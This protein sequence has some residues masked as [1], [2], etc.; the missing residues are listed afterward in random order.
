MY[1][2][3]NCQNNSGHIHFSG[4]QIERLD[5]VAT[6]NEA[7]AGI[8]CAVDTKRTAYLDNLQNIVKEAGNQTYGKLLTHYS[9]SWNW[10]QCN[11]GKNMIT[12]NGKTQDANHHMIDIFDSIDVQV[13]I[14]CFV[15]VW[16]EAL[17]PS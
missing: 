16:V 7:Y 3:L 14:F 2:Q 12:W 11:G 5:G 17:Q 13:K 10:G 8:K 9:V 1:V 4:S 15:F 6:N